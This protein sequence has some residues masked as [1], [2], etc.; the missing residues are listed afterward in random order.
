MRV[1]DAVLACLQDLLFCRESRALEPC[2]RSPEVVM[3]KSHLGLRS[4]SL[5]QSAHPGADA[6]SLDMQAPMKKQT[7]VLAEEE[8]KHM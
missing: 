2:F 4:S 7:G 6:Y 5:S 3:T 8:V 1:P